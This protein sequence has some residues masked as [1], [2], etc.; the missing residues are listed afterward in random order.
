MTLK[1]WLH[2]DQIFGKLPPSVEN[3]V[4]DV[5][6]HVRSCRGWRTW[7]CQHTSQGWHDKRRGGRHYPGG[8]LD[9]CNLS[10]LALLRNTCQSIDLANQLY[11][12]ETRVITT[13]GHLLLL[14][15][16]RHHKSTVCMF[17]LHVLSWYRKLQGQFSIIS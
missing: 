5:Q 2:Q 8:G 13:L 11:V 17:S 16:F 14:R 10:L 15:L 7:C 9:Y 1:Y 6:E 4:V 12:Y 3:P